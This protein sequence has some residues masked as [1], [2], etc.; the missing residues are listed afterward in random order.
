MEANASQYWLAWGAAHM[1]AKNI[2]S[3]PIVRHET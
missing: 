1:I 2:A 3:E